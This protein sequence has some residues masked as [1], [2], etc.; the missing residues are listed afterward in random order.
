MSLSL[1][2]STKVL[3]TCFHLVASLLSLWRVLLTRKHEIIITCF[4]QNC[5]VVA[6]VTFPTFY[7]VLVYLGVYIITGLSQD[8]FL[9]FPCSMD[10]H[11]FSKRS[12]SISLVTFPCGFVPGQILSRD[13]LIQQANL[14]GGLFSSKYIFIDILLD[15]H[16]ESKIRVWIPPLPPPP[17]T[18]GLSPVKR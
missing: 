2:L 17:P 9:V 1:N 15:W 16:R 3:R 12:S 11:K 13:I 7:F 18:G 6:L 10:K 4:A 8:G 5:R 14:Y